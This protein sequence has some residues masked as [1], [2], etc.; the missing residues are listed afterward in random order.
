MKCE[1]CGGGSEPFDYRGGLRYCSHE[2]QHAAEL[3]AFE[4]FEA[5]FED[6]DPPS[7]ADIDRRI[8]QS[9]RW[10]PDKMAERVAELKAEAGL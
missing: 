3:W 10:T 7:K 4:K 5:M 9:S 2:C 1:W 8:R 6:G